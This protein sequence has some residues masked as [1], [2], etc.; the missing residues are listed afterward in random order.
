MGVGKNYHYLVPGKGPGS[1]VD[2]Q[3]FRIHFHKTTNFF[4]NHEAVTCPI[5][6]SGKKSPFLVSKFL[7]KMTHLI[8]PDKTFNV[9]IRQHA[10]K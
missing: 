1:S 3:R 4:R 5:F 7:L 10:S 9:V 8:K 6:R 2:A